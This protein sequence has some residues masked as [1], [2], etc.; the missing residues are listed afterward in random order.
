MFTTLLV[1]LACQ[2]Y[3]LNKVTEGEGEA[4]AI[5]VT[6][7][8]VLFGELPLGD[9]AQQVFTIQ[10]VGDVALAVTALEVDEGAD[11]FSITT[12]GIVG[13]YAPGE[14]ADVTVTYVSPGDPV[15]G[16]V[17]ILSNDAAS[18][19]TYVDLIG[20]TSVPD[21]VIDP[22]TVRFGAVGVGETI[23]ESVELRNI[24]E[25]PLTV[26]SVGTSDPVFAYA[27]SEALPL[28]IAP[29]ESKPVI[30]AFTPSEDGAWT[31]ELQVDSNDP[32]GREVALLNG[33]SGSQPVA[34]CDVTPRTV[35]AIHESADWIGNA[36]YDPGGYAITTYNW[37]LTSKPAGSSAFMPA[38]TA[39]RRGFVP[40][41]VGTY[42]AQ[43]IVT[44]SIGERS[45]PC[46]ATLEAE[47]FGG[48]WIEMFWRYSGDD[49]DLHLVK[50]GGSLQSTGDCYYANCT[51]GLSWGGSGSADDP[52]LDLDDIPG[53]GPENI[54]IASPQSGVFTV[55][56]H[57]YPGSVYNGRNDVTVN[58]YVGG[59]LEWTDTRNVD[60]EDYYAPFAEIDWPSGVVTS[61]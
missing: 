19:T 25:A 2:D 37:T 55:Y 28:T 7:N 50:P 14:S 31:G 38:G 56:V 24:G 58:I 61:L 20:G 57:D 47:P 4:P 16:K 54:N 34:V 12:D 30:V 45:E 13:T 6:P 29:G 51:G 48:L 46:F 39:N 43:L 11:W 40:D 52:A 44:N 32:A 5:L 22:D 35:E 27:L 1:L 41:V 33:S 18:P 49:M 59:V 15:S 60:D 23:E 8:P 9:R 26:T 36:S 10:S 3:S 53:T 42:E 17:A 21:L